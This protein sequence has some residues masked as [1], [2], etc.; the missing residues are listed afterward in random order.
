MVAMLA[1][2]DSIEE[3]GAYAR[4]QLMDLSET[5]SWMVI[6]G[7][8]DSFSFEEYLTHTQNAFELCIFKV[9]Q[10]VMIVRS[11]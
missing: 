6:V 7:V 8:K 10:I 9:N 3:C 1:T 4:A 5:Q 2:N 11:I